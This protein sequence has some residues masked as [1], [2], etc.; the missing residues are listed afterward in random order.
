MAS[1]AILAV[2]VISDSTSA[3]RDLQQTSSRYE[4]FGK[5]GAAAGKALA[6]GLL[7]AGAAAVKMTKAAAEDEAAASR[8]AN[9]LRNAAGASDS[10]V[11]AAERWI[12]AQGKALGVSDDELRPAL[13]RLVAVTK[14]VGEAQKL[15][16]LAMDISAGS[17]KSLESVSAALAKAQTGSLGG[18]GRLGVATKNAAGET[19]SLA[20]IQRDLSKTYSGAA[21]KAADTTAGKQKILAVRFDELQE[22]I[23][24]KLI[25]VLSQL[26]EVGLKVVTWIDENTTTALVLVGVVGGLLAV[27]WAVSKAVAAWSAI[28]KI[29]AAVQWAWNAAMSANPIGLVI[30]AVVA[31][32]AA[33]VIAYKK[34]ETFR[35]IVQA[36]ARGAA[37][38]FGWVVDK[39]K[40]LIG[41]VKA[42]APAAFRALGS[43][44]VKVF[45]IITTPTRLLIKLLGVVVGWIKDRAVD[46]WQKL[47][48]VAVAVWDRI[49][50]GASSVVD[51]FRT[52]VSFIRERLGGAF[53]WV[54][55]KAVGVFQAIAS[56]VQWV[57]DKVKALI[58]WIKNIDFP[59]PP[60]LNPFNGR[61]SSTP[62]EGTIGRGLGSTTPRGA[63]ENHTW[64]IT[65]ALDPVAVGN[66]IGAILED[67][68]R[69]LGRR[70]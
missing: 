31:L 32:V 23:G 30:I 36:V 26:A 70:R 41:W 15:S 55:Q 53:T 60:D 49:K 3:T 62:N 58:D 42:K 14:D 5:V 12:E 43:A 61:Q 11:A 47:R 7:G 16:S 69:R 29:A 48:S 44:A 18:L 22:K 17:G 56:K 33:I 57:I 37:R 52:V 39:V 54:R 10:Q 68:D 45:K 20:A 24:A 34:S 66:Q 51:K 2:K 1:T 59:D 38:A 27:T 46:A 19:K 8:L 4:K 25:P 28:M 6:I 67:R 9:T 40:D 65:G 63:T 13:G 50:S 64:N 21:S 35:K